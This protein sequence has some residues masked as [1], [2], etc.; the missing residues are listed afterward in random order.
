[1]ISYARGL[2]LRHGDRL[3]VFKNRIDEIKVQF[4]YTDNGQYL[5]ETVGQNY[6]AIR[7]GKYQLARASAQTSQ[8]GPQDVNLITLPSNLSETQEEDI[9]YKLKYVRAVIRERVPATALKK[10]ARL[11][12][13]IYE[14][15]RTEGESPLSMR[16]Y[17]KPSAPTVRN[18]ITAYKKSGS[19]AF[20]LIDKRGV[21][22]RSK[23]IDG[24]VEEIIDEVLRK[25]YLKIK[26]DSIN[27]SYDYL[28]REIRALNSNAGSAL[29]M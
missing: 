13:R 14:S 16:K 23:R 3:M 2:V 24:R 19:N 25:R 7:S 26:G 28:V 12:D 4:E 29:E 22:K 1:M 6:R 21:A 20:M 18:W 15:I 9:A 5:T 11:I 10:I 27:S 8:D 17:P